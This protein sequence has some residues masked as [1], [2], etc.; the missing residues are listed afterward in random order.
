MGLASVSKSNKVSVHTKQKKSTNGLLSANVLWSFFV[1]LIHLTG[2]IVEMVWSVLYEYRAYTLYDK[3]PGL[4]ILLTKYSTSFVSVIAA[5]FNRRKM[6]SL[7]MNLT[8]IDQI[9]LHENCGRVYRKSRRILLLELSLI[10]TLLIGFYCYHIYT[11]PE[12][13]VSIINTFDFLAQISNIIMV[14]QYINIIQILKHRFRNLNQQLA[15]CCDSKSRISEHN[16]IQFRRGRNRLNI[17]TTQTAS[18]ANNLTDIPTTQNYI[19]PDISVPMSNTG[20]NEVSRIHTLRQT[21]S[22]LYD[23]TETVNGIYGYQITLELHYDFISFVY[24]L[25]IVLDVLLNVKNTEESNP[26]GERS[27]MLV[28]APILCWLI[29]TVVRILSITGS[30]F[31]ASEEARR[32]GTVVHKLLLRRSLLRDTSKE[33][34]LFSIQLEGS[35]VEFSAGGFFPLNLSLVYRM[36]GAATTY[37]I[38]LFKFK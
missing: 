35:K 26:E 2:F 33:L 36:V 11:R 6:E 32:T 4:L 17:R 22:D 27:T 7:M 38:I 28:V 13:I 24:G 34:Q 5:V 3:V 20:P 23:I 31:A 15:K 18:A 30:C 25:H 1:F 16:L 21:H 12:G 19:L 9:L 14:I 29:L 8:A 10:F 37:I